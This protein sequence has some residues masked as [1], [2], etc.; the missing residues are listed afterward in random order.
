MR[1][2]RGWERKDERWGGRRRRGGG[3]EYKARKTV[4]DYLSIH[5]LVSIAC[6]GG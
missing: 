2:H 4:L 6:N 1:V 5:C 3:G